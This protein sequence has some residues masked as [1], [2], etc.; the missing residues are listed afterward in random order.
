MVH[1]TQ[2]SDAGNAAPPADT[3]GPR[4]DPI[5]IRHALRR[6]AWL[7]A[8][9]GIAFGV[10]TI[11]AW[12]LLRVDR[13]GLSEATDADAYYSDTGFGA[14]KVAGLYLLPFAAILFLWFIVALR[15]W[16]RGTQHRRNML[17]SDLQLVSGVVF[18]GLFLVGAAAMATSV[19]VAG[20]DTGELSIS[21]LQ[22]LASF[23]DTLMLVMG[24]RIAAIFVIATASLGMTTGALPRW[25]NFVSYGFG[26]I[27]MITPMVEASFTVAFPVWV[28]V[29]SVMLVYHMANLP[30][31]QIPGFAMRYAE[32]NASD[33]G[34]DSEV[35]D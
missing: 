18:I 21:S 19:V 33:G 23:G 8:G 32:R 4:P 5:A 7:T 16:I 3:A 2:T 25:F 11:V 30:T 12:Y 20:S 17:I 10:L 28:I 24:V 22:M 15:G 31:D 1:M 13:A 14:S 6:A 34:A 26:L 9:A 27:L 35:S 29:L